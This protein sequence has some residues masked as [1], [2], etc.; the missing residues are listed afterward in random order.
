MSD[1]GPKGITY[2][3]TL[4]WINLTES[5]KEKSLLKLNM[6]NDDKI[7]SEKYSNYYCLYLD[8]DNLTTWM[9]DLTKKNKINNN[10]DNEI[11]IKKCL[12]YII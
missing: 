2:S 4:Q 9:M 8:K 3:F 5:N 10:N 1:T 12:R 7:R 6:V 11:M